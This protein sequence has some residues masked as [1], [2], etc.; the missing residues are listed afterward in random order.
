MKPQAS[1]Q[2]AYAAGYDAFLAG[3]RRDTNIGLYMPRETPYASWWDAGYSD[4]QVG[5]PKK[6]KEATE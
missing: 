4:A 5:N 2:R 1:G 6:Y 3:K